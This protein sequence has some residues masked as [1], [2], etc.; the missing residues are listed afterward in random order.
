VVFVEEERDSFCIS[1]FEKEPE[2]M[3]GAFMFVNLNLDDPSF[4]DEWI[5]KYSEEL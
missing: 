3:E 5:W 2:L 4:G 1:C